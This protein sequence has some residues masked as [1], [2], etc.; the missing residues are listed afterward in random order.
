M[1]TPNLALE[2][3]VSAQAQKH[4]TVNEALARVDAA[5]QLAVLDR[6]LTDPPASPA[7][8]DRYLLPA[9]PTGAW[10]GRGGDIAVWEDATLGWLFLTP[11]IGWRVWAI[12]E[13]AFL[14]LT[15]SGWQGAGGGGGTASVN[16]VTGG[17]LGVNTTADP[18]NR[19]AVKTDAALLSHDDVTPGSGDMR[20]TL[21]KAAP[22]NDTS[23]TMQTGYSARAQIGLTGDDDLHL[24]VSPDGTTFHEA[25]VA[26][27]ATGV[28]SQP[29]APVFSA[30][31]PG[32]WRE[33]STTDTDLAFTVALTNVG[34]HYDTVTG[35]FTAPVAGAYCF[36]IN[37]FLGDTT[38]GRIT[39]AKNGTALLTQMQALTGAVPLSFTAM[40]MLD[41]GDY[42]TCRTGNVGTLLRY[43]L[44]HTMLSG[45]KV[46]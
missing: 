29:T 26:D 35:R 38:D 31:T 20:L 10:S 39:F 15:A 28:L 5:A 1:R 33:I 46:A 36:L 45:W 42:V 30:Y 25:L 13:G 18:V 27:N 40:I 34:G 3:L 44:G 6:D 22:S 2:P 14:I 16:P 21:D 12:D 19:L 43:Y 8:G 11:R 4:V 24:K 7:D 37:G 23:L 32:G 17:L 9:A 41:V